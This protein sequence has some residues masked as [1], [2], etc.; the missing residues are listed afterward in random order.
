MGGEEGEVE[1]SGIGRDEREVKEA[2]CDGG[3][4]VALP[5]LR[6]LE[7]NF[8]ANEGTGN[9]GEAKEAPE[10]TTPSRSEQRRALP[11]SSRATTPPSSSLRC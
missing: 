7:A 6:L 4:D 5:V 11:A 2:G 10:A 1:E 8:F 3:W 9:E